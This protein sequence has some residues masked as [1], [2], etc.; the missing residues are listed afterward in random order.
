MKGFSIRIPADD[1]FLCSTPTA[2]K[3]MERERALHYSP[4]SRSICTLCYRILYRFFRENKFKWFRHHCQ[5]YELLLCAWARSRS[6]PAGV[7]KTTKKNALTLVVCEKVT[8]SA[9]WAFFASPLPI[10]FPLFSDRNAHYYSSW[11]L[12]ALRSG[13]SFARVLSTEYSN[14]YYFQDVCI[15]D[16]KRP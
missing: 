5:D 8:H 2:H 3:R 11:W 16:H 15:I 13:R 10:L 14:H 7:P 9:P 12:D 4:F 1:I 6:C